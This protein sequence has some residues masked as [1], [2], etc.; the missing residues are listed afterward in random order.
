MRKYF[1]ASAALSLSVA[2]VLVACST[3]TTESDDTSSEDASTATDSSSEGDASAADS[4]VD[5]SSSE[6]AAPATDIVVTALVN[7]APANGAAVIVH[8]ANGAVLEVL[9]TNAEGKAV[10]KA[11]GAEMITVVGPAAS[12]RSMVTVVDAKAGDDLVVPFFLT[13]DAMPAPQLAISLPIQAA[14]DSYY[15]QVGMCGDGAGT[16]ISFGLDL[17]S[18]GLG[19]P[20]VP[21]LV[22]SSNGGNLVASISKKDVAPKADGGTTAV[23]LTGATWSTAS[24][25]LNVAFSGTPPEGASWRVELISAGLPFYVA[26]GDAPGTVAVPAGFAD[27]YQVTW[28]TS[29]STASRAVARRVATSQKT[30]STSL[31][32]FLP[33]LTIGSS[34]TTTPLRP[35]FNWSFPAATQIDG[36]TVDTFGEFAGGGSFNWTFVIPPTATSIKIP[37]LP[38]TLALGQIDISGATGADADYVATYDLFRKFGAALV[39]TGTAGDVATG[40]IHTSSRYVAR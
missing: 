21:L 22:T 2:A 17:A 35:V 33:E 7:G 19:R 11:T 28:F 18:C 12:K 4:A 13:S 6:D 23:D 39:N 40:T 26:D 20:T 30:I 8:D 16:S 1:A 14:S 34:D 10:R 25:T 3:S 38:D 37:A 32:E 29:A 31:A 5:A 15:A 9:S 24:D 36:Y 27:A